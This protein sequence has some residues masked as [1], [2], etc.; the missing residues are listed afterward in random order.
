MLATIIPICWGVLECGVQG[1]FVPE[2]AGIRGAPVQIEVIEKAHVDHLHPN[3]IVPGQTRGFSRD[4]LNNPGWDNA[5][6]LR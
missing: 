4:F 6:A 2:V 3:L 1:S 5:Q